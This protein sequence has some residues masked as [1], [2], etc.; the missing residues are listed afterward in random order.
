MSKYDDF[1][2]DMREIALT[3]ESPGSNRVIYTVGPYCATLTELS[4]LICG[5]SSLDCITEGCTEVGCDL[6]DPSETCS[7]C[8][9]Y[10]GGACKR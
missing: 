9:S 2:L 5:T 10:C 3:S 6:G 7:Q 8:R 4:S 1:D